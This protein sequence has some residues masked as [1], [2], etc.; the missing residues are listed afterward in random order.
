MTPTDT[1]PHAFAGTLTLEEFG[2]VQR[3]ILPKWV[4]W[5]VTLP[6]LA[7][8]TFLGMGA[9][10]N[11]AS[12]VLDLVILGLVVGSLQVVIRRAAVR[13]WKQTVQL[14]GRVHGRITHE[15]IE[16]NTDRST[17]RYEWARIV[18][19][20]QVDDLTLAFY[21]PRCAFYFPRSFFDSDA[22]WTAFNAAIA[23]HAGG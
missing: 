5:Y 20:K 22:R 3:A 6:L 12:L 13:Q 2:R 17:S 16:W 15:G 21:A 10:T 14:V 18:E 11:V 19:V 7:I 4:R 8:A 23:A 1:P 9:A